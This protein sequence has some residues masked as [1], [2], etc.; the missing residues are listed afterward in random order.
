MKVIIV[1]QRTERSNKNP[2]RNNDESNQHIFSWYNTSEGNIPLQLVCLP[3]HGHWQRWWG[4][5]AEC[6]CRRSREWKYGNW[7]AATENKKREMK[8]GLTFRH[9]ASSI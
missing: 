6:F 3:L 1:S 8:A 2:V 4:A 7:R 5:K 9:R